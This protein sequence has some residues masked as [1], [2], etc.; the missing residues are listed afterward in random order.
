MSVTVLGKTLAQWQ[1]SS[2]EQAAF[3]EQWLKADKYQLTT[4]EFCQSLL[5]NGTD[6]MKLIGQAGLNAPAQGLRFVDVLDGWLPAIL[7]NS[8]RAAESAGQRHV[9]LQTALEQLS[10]GEN[11]IA[12]VVKM[13]A[14]PY[15][16]ALG[17]GVYGVYIA[18]KM[19]AAV[20][21]APGLGL[22]VRDAFAH[23]GLW[24]ALALIALLLALAT[25]LPSWS[26]SSRKMSQHWPLFSLYRFAVAATLL[27]TLANLTQCGMKLDD[28]LTEVQRRN[29]PFATAHIQRMR[30][31]AIGQTNLGHILDTGL[32]R[33]D[34][35]SALKVLGARVSY[36]ELLRESGQHHS[37]YVAKQLQKMQLWLPKVGLI[38]T[39][40]ILGAL[41]SAA[42]Y[43]LYLS[44]I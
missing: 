12:K 5:D 39:I 31:Q 22:T 32:L 34:E 2:K 16:L 17:A 23:Y 40:L 20:E 21:F 8:I 27:K 1:F 43:Q 33:P 26:G 37:D 35:L 3:L 44:L 38:T 18:D 9:G 6:A 13:L 29:T 15:L 30:E 25:A 19:L 10:G 42:T 11:I 4:K 7:L 14:L 36:T 41:I 24:V 28:A